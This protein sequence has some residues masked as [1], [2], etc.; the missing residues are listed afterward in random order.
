MIVRPQRYFAW[1]IARQ[2]FMGHVTF[3]LVTL[4]LTGFSLRYYVYTNFLNTADIHLALGRFDSYLTSLFITVLVGAIFYLALSART[5]AR[6]LGRLIQKARELRRF[7]QIEESDDIP[8]DGLNEEP[9]E[10]N[11]LERAL[12]RIHRELR[13]KTKAL[14]REREELSALIGAVSDAILAVDR[15]GTP[16]FFN[17]PFALLF[18]AGANASGRHWSLSEVFRTP[19]ILQ[20]YREVL[21]TGERRYLTATIHT[22]HHSMPRHFSISL[23]P[24][25][26]SQP[27]IQLRSGSN[28]PEANE[29]EVVETSSF[30]PVYG[31][32]G[33]FH[34][35]TELKQAE[36]IR[37]EFV[38]NAS[39]ELR[40]PLTNIKG[41]V[42]T[43]RGDVKSGH[44]DEASKFIDVISR[45]VDRLILLVNDLLDLSTLES[46]SEL[47]RGLV[48]TREVTEAALKQVETKRAAKHQ[49]IQTHFQTETF[50]A[51]SHRVEQ[52][53]VNLVHNAIKYIPEGKRIDVYWEG[54]EG[55]TV[56]RVK[57]NGL[58][59]PTEHQSRLF[60]RFYRIDNGR[61]RDQGGTGL[62][63]SIIKHI[64][65]KHG[66]SVRLV[67]KPGEG[68]EFICAF[69]D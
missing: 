34:D 37:I 11:D 55:Q 59:I 19:E 43:L 65:L 45:N 15:D 18:R 28:E 51:D 39:H 5:Y 47:K 61:S 21:E 57:D 69:P 48:S 50:L 10:W 20:G 41:Y 17:S 27:G 4:L 30:E 62:G 63:L 14:S 7:D 46:G 60:E 64:M 66:G 31:A 29:I 53:L 49:E 3:V 35:I 33:I 44:L 22:A 38:G 2:F 67:S 24:L 23:S 16:L 8:V 1:K 25:R 52:V 68:A 26:A 54:E 58:G 42:E 13:G 56:L 32:L 36:Q 12:N 6:P 40:T 9:G